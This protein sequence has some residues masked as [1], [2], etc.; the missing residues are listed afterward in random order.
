MLYKVNIT[1]A[2]FAMSVRVRALVACRDTVQIEYTIHNTQ[3]LTVLSSSADCETDLLCSLSFPLHPSFP[4][5]EVLCQV[6]VNT[7]AVVLSGSTTA[8]RLN[9]LLQ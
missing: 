5:S 3:S 7:E 6:T 8:G 9:L 4:I 1:G 2:P